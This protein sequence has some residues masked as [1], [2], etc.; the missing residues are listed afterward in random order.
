MHGQTPEAL[1]AQRNLGD[2]AERLAEDGLAQIVEITVVDVGA[3]SAA[4][5]AVPISRQSGSATRQDCP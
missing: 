1:V 4:P 2:G 5:S 3:A